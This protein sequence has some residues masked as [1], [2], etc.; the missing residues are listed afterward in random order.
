MSDPDGEV[1]VSGPV[2]SGHK[3][4]AL[5]LPFDPSRRWDLRAVTF[6][7][8]R[9]GVPV[10]VRAEGGVDACRHVVTRAGRHWL[11]L[12]PSLE[13]SLAC[14]AGDTVRVRVAPRVG[15]ANA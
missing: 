6:A 9:R 12:P 14:A 4:D 11:L 8:G 7:P 3:E 10:R 13:R 2:R 15:D 5:E 1:E